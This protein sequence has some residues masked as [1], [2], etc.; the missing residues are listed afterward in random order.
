LIL[1]PAIL[2]LIAASSLT[3]LMVLYACWFG[4]RILLQ[5]EIR[6]GSE[7]QLDLERR[8][9]LIS[10]LLCFAFATEIL[11]LFLY[12]FTADR[13][14]S[15]FSGA[16]C[17]AGTLNVNPYGYPVLLLK[18]GA[19]LLAGVW[20]IVNHADTRGYDYPLIRT[21]YALLL[22][23][24][25]LVLA[26]GILQYRYFANLRAD[27]I[28]SCCGSLFSRDRPGVAGDL[29]A[30][31]RVPME[32]LFFGGMAATGVAGIRFWRK[33]SGGYLFS[34]AGTLAFFIGVAATISFLCLYYYD[35]PTH[36]CPFCVLQKEYGY[37]GYPLYA[38]LFG[39]GVAAMGTGALMPFR[40][41][42]SMA[43]V[44]PPLQRRLVVVTL[45]LYLLFTLMVSLRM[46]LS[47]LRL[48]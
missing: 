21:K 37:V 41:R 35:L 46:A 11:S 36:H 2:A 26:E 23:I 10:T 16:M 45:F 38:S 43:S 18:G 20:L 29:A 28:T 13:L 7:R 17:A 12:V 6:S 39:G 1:H 5:W 42:G 33:G 47:P 25:P 27:V 19:F 4:T 31:P 8:T 48:G 24:A 40:N 30:L 3:G 32:W 34:A 22:L 9:Y 14:H 44:I 15:L